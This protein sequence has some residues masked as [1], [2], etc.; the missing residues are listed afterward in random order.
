MVFLKPRS[1]RRCFTSQTTTIIKTHRHN[2]K[3]TNTPGRKEVKPFAMRTHA[4][5]EV[6]DADPVFLL[7]LLRSGRDREC[8]SESASA[9]RSSFPAREKTIF[10]HLTP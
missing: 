7:R 9:I 1:D 10:G 4:W 8:G 2:D 5:M 6:V 3:Q